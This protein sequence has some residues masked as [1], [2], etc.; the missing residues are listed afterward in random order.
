L[1]LLLGLS[2]AAA[3][4]SGIS[5]QDD[6]HH[7]AFAAA[8]RTAAEVPPRPG[9]GRGIASFVLSDD[10]T[11]LYY[12]VQV[13][14][15]SGPASAAHIHAGSA[16]A[17]GD[18]IVNLCGAGSTPACESDGLIASG[19]IDASSLA[20]PF[21]GFSLDD[22]ISALSSDATYVNVHTQR[23]P[24]GEIRGQVQALGDD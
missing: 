8:M 12:S 14:D 16:G 19:A 21:A 9:A 23:Y 11:L 5:A 15:L 7:A 6:V 24:N 4:P 10:G 17:N 22:L 1:V 13:V 20:G 2:L 3:A 18:V